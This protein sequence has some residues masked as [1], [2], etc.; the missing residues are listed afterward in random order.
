[1]PLGKGPG[2]GKN[3]RWQY[4][5]MRNPVLSE[6]SLNRKGNILVHETK[7]LGNEASDIAACKCSVSLGISLHVPALLFSLLALFSSS[8][9]IL[10]DKHDHPPAAPT[11]LFSR[12]LFLC[13]FCSCTRL[14]HMFI[15]EQ[16]LWL[17]DRILG[18]RPQLEAGG[19]SDSPKTK[20]GRE[21]Q[22]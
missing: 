14:G 12:P 20:Q 1:M 3:G 22:C 10:V 13:L 15:P 9:S 11:Y 4:L 16:S 17:G 5:G 7:V 19:R 6:N 8:P 21:S 18:Q 2:R